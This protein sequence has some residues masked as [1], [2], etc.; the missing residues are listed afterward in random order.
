MSPKDLNNLSVIAAADLLAELKSR[1]YLL[2]CL[3][4]C[5]SE[6]YSF[7]NPELKEA[8]DNLTTVLNA[9]DLNYCLALINESMERLDSAIDIL[10][11]GKL[12][13]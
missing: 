4:R 8:L 9:Y 7:D 1:H 5:I 3:D 11:S 2:V 6:H 13:T 10:R 12:G